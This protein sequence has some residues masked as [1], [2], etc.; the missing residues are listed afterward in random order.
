VRPV[1]AVSALAAGAILVAAVHGGWREVEASNGGS[2][3]VLVDPQGNLRVPDDYRA[4]Y[5]FLG[6]WAIAADSGSGSKEL[7]VV[8]ASP[9]A[10][11]A[12][13]KDGRFPDGTVLV[14][15]VYSAAT[16]EMTTGSVSRAD[17]LKGWFVMVKGDAARFPGNAL[18]GDG[19]GWS[20]FDASN[21]TKTTSTNYRVNCKSCH[22]PAQ[23]TEWVYVNGYPSLKRK[24][25]GGACSQ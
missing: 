16:G 3:N 17:G 13:R 6:S 15:E 1:S 21:P 14:K 22:V 24:C 23:A 5:Q 18:W 12:Y 2:K 4:S 19:W 20:W 7:H 9:G 8:F 25:A 10:S 11:D